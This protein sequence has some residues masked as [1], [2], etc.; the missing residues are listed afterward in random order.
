MRPGQGSVR[1]SLRIGGIVL[2]S[3]RDQTCCFTG[4]RII[5]AAESEDIK[6]WIWRTVHELRRQH[7]VRF[8]GAGGALGFDTLA[9]ETVLSLREALDLRLIIVA[10]C[11]GQ[12][13][14]WR[15]ADQKKYQ[16]I[17]RA[18]DKT[19]FLSDRYY[20]GCMQGR[21][22]HLVDGSRWCVSYQV[23]DQGGTAY[24]VGYAKQQGLAIINY[25]EKIYP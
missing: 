14:R 13:A 17:L 7:N 12:E 22:R 10:P 23:K 3:L 16:D 19:V 1:A 11:R 2:L 18:A 21:N 25:P 9:A 15:A 5:P 6:L 20:P 8:F 24:T 4:H